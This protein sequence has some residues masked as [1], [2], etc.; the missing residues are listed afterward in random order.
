MTNL[1]IVRDEAATSYAE[2]I[3]TYQRY[4]D[5]DTTIGLVETVEMGNGFRALYPL[6]R[7]KAT[8]ILIR[9]LRRYADYL[10]HGH[11]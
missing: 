11:Q 1:N 3:Q 5:G 9:E 4:I 2:S 10:E 6:S 7:E 8:E